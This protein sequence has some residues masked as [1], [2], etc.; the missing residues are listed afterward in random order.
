MQKIR[1]D[2]VVRKIEEF[3]ACGQFKA[4]ERIP[5]ER[6]LA[7][8]FQVSRNTIREAIKALAEKGVLVSRRGAGTFVAQGALAC[9][10]YGFTRR[11][12]RLTEIFELRNLL[13]PQIARLA[14]RRIT[15]EQIEILKGIVQQQRENLEDKTIQAMLDDQ[16]HSLIVQAAGNTVL[17]ELYDALHGALTESRSQ[18]LQS[19]ERN[20]RSM[21]YHGRLVEAL[22]AHA[23][24]QAATIMREH[25]QQV[26]SNFE[27][28]VR[29]QHHTDGTE[30]LLENDAEPHANKKL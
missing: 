14:A 1:H 13:E 12:K 6:D 29:A 8:H 5:P 7:D 18:E 27:Q 20:V 23:E 9:V 21:E 11:H 3:I 17:S 15:S 26:E 10:V 2:Q 24:S 25:M 19:Y 22:E 16:F 30:H 28:L 4:G